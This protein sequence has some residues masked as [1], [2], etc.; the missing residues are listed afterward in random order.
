MASSAIQDEF[1]D[2]AI[3]VTVGDYHYVL[4]KR[5]RWFWPWRRWQWSVQRIDQAGYHAVT[6]GYAVNRI[7]AYEAAQFAAMNDGTRRL[8]VSYREAM[9]DGE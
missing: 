5:A 4:W 3:M 8:E 6:G 7:S 2:G 1:A 9:S